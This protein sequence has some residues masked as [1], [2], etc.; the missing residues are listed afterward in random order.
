MPNESL[1]FILAF[2]YVCLLPLVDDANDDANLGCVCVSFLGR[3]FKASLLLAA[4]L[5][6]RHDDKSDKYKRNEVMKLGIVLL[7]RVFFV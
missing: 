5:K 4:I 7:Y 6:Q 1:D 3:K 2:E